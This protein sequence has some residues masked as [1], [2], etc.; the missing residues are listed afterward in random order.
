MRIVMR[1]TRRDIGGIK[2]ETAGPDL[3]A[4]KDSAPVIL[5]KIFMQLN[6]APASCARV[7]RLFI[8]THENIPPLP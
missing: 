7:L 1:H 5:A 6:G 2:D 3:A 8:K 4:K